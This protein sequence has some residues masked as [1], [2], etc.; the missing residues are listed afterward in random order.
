MTN[1]KVKSGDVFTRLTT[2]S[3]TQQ[4]G[5]RAWICKCICGVEKTVLQQS[6]KSNGTKSCGCLWKD[7]MIPGA[8][9]M[10][11]DMIGLKFKKWTILSIDPKRAKNGGIYFQCQCECGTIRPVASTGLIEGN[12]RS[13]GCGKKQKFCKRGHE[14]D[15]TGRT[16][17]GSCRLCVKDKSLMRN[18]G[19]TLEEYMKILRFQEF[20]CAICSKP[21]N[22]SISEPGWV[23]G[24]GR[25]EL[26]HRHDGK[27]V[28]KELVRGILCG[29]RW[30]GC[31]R[32]LGRIDNID[33]LEK[34]L[35][36]LKSP[37]AKKIL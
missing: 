25:P 10:A 16:P 23:K 12:T 5:K 27:R 7:I 36:Y 11:R 35:L 20:K 34:V 1:K 13:C 28:D 32:K 33:W 9:K 37:P 30:A 2:I 15:L 22:F 24:T 18:Y 19:I 4:N 21:L 6:L 17:T 31:N 8:Q 29:G 3:V 14:T 26:D